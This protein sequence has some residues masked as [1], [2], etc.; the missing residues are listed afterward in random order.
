MKTAN[1]SGMEILWSVVDRKQVV[2]IQRTL[3]KAQDKQS[4][5]LLREVLTNLG[6]RLDLDRGGQDA[7]G[8]VSNLN[9]NSDPANLRNQVFKA[10][11]SLGMRL[12][13]MMFANSLEASWG[14]YAHP[15]F[16]EA[17]LNPRSGDDGTSPGDGI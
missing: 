11:N 15:Q 5:D 6:G 1:R 2:A 13:S 14:P 3:L 12:P 7:L 8:R 16:R 10:A 4:A 17:A 9:P